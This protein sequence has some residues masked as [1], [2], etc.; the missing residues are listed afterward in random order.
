MKLRTCWAASFCGRW[1]RL[2]PYCASIGSFANRYPT[3]RKRRSALTERMSDE[4]ID[5]LVQSAETFSSPLS[6]L[7]FFHMHGAATRPQPTDTAFAARQAQWDFDAI[8]QWD[9]V[10]S[11]ARHIA[12]LR[13]LWAQLE[14]HLAGKAYI[15]HLAADD[16]PET[17]RA[18]FGENYTR[19]RQIKAVYDK[20]NLF[21]LNANIAPA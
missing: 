17:V 7:I 21:R 1:T 14:P 3:T 18:S 13:A 2:P 6:A 4:L 11:S 10:G 8:A 20:T 19:L 12:W 16:R 5:I 9:D 15:N